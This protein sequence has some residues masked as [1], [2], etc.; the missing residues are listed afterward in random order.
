MTTCSTDFCGTGL[1]NIVKPGD[2]DNFSTLL[3]VSAYGGVDVSWS[4][5]TT[6][7][8]AVAY[9]RVYRAVLD[10]FNAATIIAEVGNT[11]FY[12]RMQDSQ[13]LYY[14]YWISHVSINGTIFDPI[15]P[16][17]AVALPKIDETIE[18]LTGL[19]DA[20]V[21]ASS[22]RAKIDSIDTNFGLFQSEIT[23]RNEQA[24]LFTA[25]LADVQGGINSVMTLVNEEITNRQDGESAFVAQSNLI[26]AATAD[27]FAAVETS[28]QAGFN[29]I[30]GTIEDIGALYTAK[31]TVNN[32]VGGFGIYNDGT[33]V[34]AGFD[35]DTFWVGRTQDNKRKPFIVQNN[36]VYLD[37]AAIA[38]ASITLAQIDKATIQN[39]SALN[40]DMGNIT[41]GKI[42]FAQPGAPTNYIQIDS[43][44][45]TLTV[46]NAG[47][48]R[49]K[50]GNL[51]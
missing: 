13:N 23:E 7:P 32:L 31:L 27:N 2:P 30:N 46:Y 43:A 51:A 1:G 38:D 18:Q 48:L 45:Q 21:L 11:F 10:D 36:V 39:L 22:L 47:V 9:T 37:K 40:A 6:N 4:M 14:Y 20:G 35:V 16:A 33:T 49:V 24:I 26:A 8:H 17:G 34:E 28:M 15:G 41:A 12:D 3:A 42:K 5:P 44:T 29:S 25:M 50:I 19:I